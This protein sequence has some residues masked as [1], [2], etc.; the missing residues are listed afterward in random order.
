[1]LAFLAEEQSKL[2]LWRQYD[3]T[4]AAEDDPYFKLGKQFGFADDVARAKG[5]IADLAFGYSGGEGAFRKFAGEAAS[6]E[7][8]NTL[9]RN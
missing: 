6:S 9:K 2:G 1:M 5:K 8:A 3:Q 7:E 4:G